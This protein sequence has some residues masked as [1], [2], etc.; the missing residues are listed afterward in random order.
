MRVRRIALR[1]A[2][3]AL[4]LLLADGAVAALPRVI[5]R[6]FLDQHIPLTG[7]SAYVQELG[8]V[9]PVFSQQPGR[10]MSAASTMKLVTTLAGLELLR[11][12]FR[13]KTEAYAAGQISGGVLQGDLVL[14]GYGDPKITVEQFQELIARL[15]ATGLTQITG[16]LVVDRSYFAPAP[17]DPAAFDNEPLRPYNV[18]PDALLINFKSVR[19]VFSPNAAG[20]A[21]ETR[22]E[23]ALANVAV[24]SAPRLVAGE[25]GDWKAGLRA[26]FDDRGDGADVRFDGDYPAACGEREWFVALLDGPHYVL[27]AFA[28]MWADAGGSF[29]GTVREGRAPVGAKPIAILQSP[30]LYDAVRDINKLSNNVMARQLFLTLATTTRPPPATAVDSIRAVHRWLAGHKLRF[31]ELVLDN[32]S[33]LSRR[34]RISARSMARLLI[35]A[36]SSDVRD[37]YVSSLAVAATDG[38]VRKRFLADGVADQAFLKTGTLDGVRAIAGYVFDPAGRR[39][40]VVCFVNHRNAARAQAPLDLLVQWVYD[41]GHDEAHRFPR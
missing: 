36:D 19:F 40:V 13:W 23:P 26:Q 29:G 34:A 1:L 3:A 17:Y 24:H 30:P 38:T 35:A 6:A 7:V 31:P 10:P 25:C 37:E 5:A 27:G 39:F 9:Q 28:R 21:V 18:G 20:D 33:G 41:H 22:A 32:G 16:D 15:R 11:P 8:D 12:D 4:A 14:K 2:L